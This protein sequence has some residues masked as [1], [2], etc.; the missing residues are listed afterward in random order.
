MRR[1]A[2]ALVLTTVCAVTP[3]AADPVA[4]FYKG[5]Q[6][7][8][9]IRSN[10]GG[11]YDL[12]GRLLS[13]HMSRHIPGNP[14]ILPIN[15][16][17]GG[18]IKA[19]N[20]VAEIAPRDGTILTLVSQGL[21][22]D[23]GLGLNPSFTADL[24]S[25][26]WVGNVSSAG[27]VVVAWHTAPVKTL[28]EAMRREM[29]MGT[30][31]AGSIAVQIAAVLVNVVGAKFKLV[32][33]YGDAHDV[34]LAMERGEVEGRS[35][36]PWPSYLAATPHYVSDKL[37]VPLVQV[38]IDKEPAL[39]DVPLLRD[40]ARTPQQ[41]EVYDFMSQAVAVGRPIATT[42]GVPADRL[43]ALRK[44]FDETLADPAFIAE[45]EK[46]RLELRPMDGGRLA[47]LIK[48]LIETPADVRER[49]KLA[50][51]PKNAQTLPSAKPAE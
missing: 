36:S 4:D 5:K 18:G 33:G 8:F 39:Q 35:A 48:A 47:D 49:I 27:Q 42:P 32:V 51:Q 13:R 23:Q 30:T 21:P 28:D 9:I 16:G 10:V 40:L 7:R 41:H 29:V 11:T 37:I 31:G 6:M 12:Y 46:Q 43:A 2:I 3:A 24:R 19:A 26:N 34:N 22:V 20:Y 17:G 45:A 1:L 44:A 15:M 25:F 50:I 14:T 38:G